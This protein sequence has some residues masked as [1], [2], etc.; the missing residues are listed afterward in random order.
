MASGV[1]QEFDQGFR[2][3][4]G[5][6]NGTLTLL[7]WLVEDG[8]GDR[9]MLGMDAA[10]QG[11]WTAYGGTP[12]MTFLL[13]AFSDAMTARGLGADVQQALFVANPARAFAFAEVRS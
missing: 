12:G 11:Y 8:F 3:K 9:L 2:W 4:D 7:D 13:G 6:D 10:R 5:V 1:C